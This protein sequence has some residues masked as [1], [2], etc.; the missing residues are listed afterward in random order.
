M[1]LLTK[2]IRDRIPKLYSQENSTNPLV[3]VKFF[4][5][6]SSWTWLATEGEPVIDPDTGKEVDFRFFGLVVGLDT[7]F[8][9]F[10]LSEF[11][12]VN[13]SKR[14][15]KPNT[16]HWAGVEREMYT[17]VKPI[18]DF[19]EYKSEYG[20]AGPYKGAPVAETAEKQCL[21]FHRDKMPIVPFDVNTAGGILE[22]G[23]PL[24][25]TQV[26]IVNVASP[27]YAF[28]LTNHIDEPWWENNGVELVGGETRSTS[29]GDIIIAPDLTCYLFNGA[30][31]VNLDQAAKAAGG[32]TTKQVSADSDIG[33]SL[34]AD[35]MAAAPIT[36]DELPPWKPTDEDLAEWNGV[37]L[38]LLT[39]NP[40]S[41]KSS[42][43]PA[44]ERVTRP[45]TLKLALAEIQDDPWRQRPIEKKLAALIEKESVPT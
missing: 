12:S 5:P 26:A 19:S 45:G 39:A 20:S 44:L 38:A 18:R 37:D 35:A 8:G 30:T 42:F 41:K 32:V 31:V 11:D 36:A 15:G 23:W 21:V 43:R 34:I 28:Q 29:I 22:I 6:M 4:T 25:Y 10:H 27:N 3:H 16:G 14:G 13:T 33:Q 24:R 9:Y 7:E 1:K 40:R 17:K 2:E